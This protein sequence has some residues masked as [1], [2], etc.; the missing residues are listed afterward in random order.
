MFQRTEKVV[1]LQPLNNKITN[2]LVAQL[3]SASD[4]GSEGYRFESCRGHTQQKNRYFSSS[5][6][7]LLPMIGLIRIRCKIWELDK[8]MS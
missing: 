3:N 7:L 5:D 2:G 8:K 4:Y 6:F 1:Y